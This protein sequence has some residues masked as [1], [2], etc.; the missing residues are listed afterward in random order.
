V[1]AYGIPLRDEIELE[2]QPL[3]RSAEDVV[4]L[5]VIPVSRVAACEW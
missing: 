4:A 5:P 1:G 3:A 2:R